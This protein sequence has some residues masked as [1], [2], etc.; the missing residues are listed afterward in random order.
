MSSLPVIHVEEIDDPIAI[1]AG[2]TTVT[3]SAPPETAICDK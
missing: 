3:I 2:G 1:E